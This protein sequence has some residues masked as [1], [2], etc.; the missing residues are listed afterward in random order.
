MFAY[1]SNRETQ[2]FNRLSIP[3][4]RQKWVLHVFYGRGRMRYCWRAEP[5]GDDCGY[6]AGALATVLFK[7]R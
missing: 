5:R 1:T 2:G 7:L 3:T 4:S 6:D